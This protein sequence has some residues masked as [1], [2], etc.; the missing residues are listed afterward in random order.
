MEPAR[1]S[2]SLWIL[3]TCL[4]L[5]LLRWTAE[6]REAEL[7]QFRSYPLV[8]AMHP[9]AA[10]SD[11]LPFLF[12]RQWG[13]CLCMRVR[14]QFPSHAP[15]SGLQGPASGFHGIAFAS[16]FQPGRIAPEPV[17]PPPRAVPVVGSIITRRTYVSGNTLQQVEILAAP[18]Q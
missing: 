16:Q 3:G 5:L 17:G 1:C 11:L 15:A 6:W 7:L 4:L 9:H 12:H 14:G 18:A 10:Q 8:G 13:Q 2:G